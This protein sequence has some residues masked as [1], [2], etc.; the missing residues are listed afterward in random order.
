M[1]SEWDDEYTLVPCRNTGKQPARTSKAHSTMRRYCES[2]SYLCQR[3]DNRVLE[4]AIVGVVIAEDYVTPPSVTCTPLP[5]FFPKM[6]V[7]FLAS[8]TSALVG[9]FATTIKSVRNNGSH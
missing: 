6:G 7:L 9:Q 5:V 1:G 4:R 8:N 2:P 3:D